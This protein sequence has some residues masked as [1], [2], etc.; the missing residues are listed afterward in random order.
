MFRMPAALIL[1]MHFCYLVTMLISLAIFCCIF[2][3]RPF[4][5]AGCSHLS[6]LDEKHL[7]QL[8]QHECSK[9]KFV[10]VIATADLPSVEGKPCNELAVSWMW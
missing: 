9:I 10:A 8:L 7:L 4:F 2:S 1:I 3:V 5:P 6:G